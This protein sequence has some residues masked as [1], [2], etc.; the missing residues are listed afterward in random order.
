MPINMKKTIE[1]LKK[2]TVILGTFVLFKGTQTVY[3]Y[4]TGE[5]IGSLPS[6][7]LLTFV[8]MTAVS[9]F[10]I[11]GSKTAQWI[12]GFYLLAQIITVFWAIFLIPTGQ[13]LLKI[14]T[15]ILSTY[16]VYGGWL[17]VRI[18]KDKHEA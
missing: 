12:M 3:A 4:A 6:L 10:V 11:K 13:L 1:I 17:L 16:F 18:A 8:V 15:I 2:P 14:T 5:R 9:F 7:H